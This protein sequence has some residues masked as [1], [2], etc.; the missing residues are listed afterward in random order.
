MDLEAI[1]AKIRA[2]RDERHWAQFHHPKDMAIVIS[3][4]ASELLEHFLWKYPEELYARISVK[5]VEIEDEIA[6][7][8]SCYKVKRYSSDKQASDEGWTHH[9]ITLT[10]ESDRPVYQPIFL[11]SSENSEFYVVGEYIA[12]FG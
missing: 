8:G 11:S 4:V 9:A 3:I 7:I 1:S 5:R 12:N 6:D 10:P 2:F